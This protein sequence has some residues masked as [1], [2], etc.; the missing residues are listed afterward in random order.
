METGDYLGSECDAE[1]HR[2]LFLRA[3]PQVDFPRA[4]LNGSRFSDPDCRLWGTMLAVK[5][6]GS[7]AHPAKYIGVA[8]LDDGVFYAVP[9]A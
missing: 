2:G 5:R 4:Y 6:H 9:R 7:W 8:S 1:G 3:Y